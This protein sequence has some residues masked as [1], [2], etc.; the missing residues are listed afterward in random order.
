M[1]AY[2]CL[3]RRKEMGM[4][5]RIA[6]VLLAGLLIGA[7]SGCAS[8]AARY[9]YS[10]LPTAENPEYLAHPFRLVALAGHAGGNLLQYGV[11]EP[12]YF[13]LTPIPDVVGLSA[14]EQRYLAQEKEVYRATFSG[15]RPLAH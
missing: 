12:F 2:G 11:I 7:L 1:S 15:Q 8:T 4:R 3:N 9:E 5:T 13:L 6:G 14:E 10:G